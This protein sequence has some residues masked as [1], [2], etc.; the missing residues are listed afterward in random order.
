MTER[1]PRADDFDAFYESWYPRAVSIARR[2]GLPDPEAAAQECLLVFWRKDYLAQHD[3]EKGASLDTWVGNILYRRITSM[4]RRE[5]RRRSIAQITPVEDQEFTDDGVGLYSDFKERLRAATKI[6]GERHPEWD[7]LW[8][9]VVVQV[10]AG[11]ATAGFTVDRR[12]LAGRAGVTQAQL[13]KDI[14]TFIELVS[15]DHE[16]A[17]LLGVGRARL[18]A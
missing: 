3:P 7:G 13:E 12:E 18:S 17:D 2:G 10:I 4:Q 16:L 1:D 15:H 14:D 9:A 8:R 5:L 6:I 11:K